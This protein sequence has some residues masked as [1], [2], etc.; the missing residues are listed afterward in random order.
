MESLFDS[1]EDQEDQDVLSTAC[2]V[3]GRTLEYRDV[4]DVCYAAYLDAMQEGPREI[5]FP[6]P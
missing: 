1:Y 2:H 3:C 4:C 5:S 6:T